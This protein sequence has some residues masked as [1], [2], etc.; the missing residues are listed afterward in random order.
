[1]RLQVQLWKRSFNEI[2]RDEDLH[3]QADYSAGQR[4]AAFRVLLEIANILGEYQEDI[5]I[6]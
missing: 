5:L 3:S 1:M 2:M 4:E 6:K